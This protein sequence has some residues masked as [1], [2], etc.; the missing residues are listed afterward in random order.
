MYPSLVY[1]YAEAWTAVLQN[2]TI[3]VWRPWEENKSQKDTPHWQFALQCG[4][5]QGAFLQ[6]QM[7]QQPCHG[8]IPYKAQGLINADG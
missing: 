6:D 5:L 2:I 4:V 1:V 7:L 3:V 8:I